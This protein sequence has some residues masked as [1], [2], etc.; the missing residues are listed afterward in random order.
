[1]D[2]IQGELRR[3]LPR[4]YFHPN[5]YRLL[6]IASILVLGVVS[7]GLLS[8]VAMPWYAKILL[9]LTI[10]YC[11]SVSGLLA[12]EILHGSVVRSR[13]WQDILGFICFLPYMI[14]PT[15]WRF[16]HN[17]L[18]H[19]HTQ[20]VIMDPDAFPTLKLFKQSRFSQRMFPFTPGSGHKRSYFYLFFWFSLNAQLIQFYFR[21]R[22]KAF[23]KVD[24]G[25]IN[26]ELILM[27]SI[28]LTAIYLVGVSAWLWAVV[29]PFFIMN[30]I[31]FSYI[32]TNH[33]MSP[34]TSKNNPL[35]NSV[36][37]LNHPLLEF[38]H[39][40][41]GYHVEHHLFPTVSGVYL[42]KI[43]QLLKDQCPEQYI[44]M[45]KWQA[46]KKLYKTPRIYKNANT[47]IHPYTGQTH[48]LVGALTSSDNDQSQPSEPSDQ[49]GQ[50]VQDV[51][52][53]QTGRA[54]QIGQNVSGS[55]PHSEVQ[56]G[57]TSRSPQ[58]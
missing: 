58:L 45:P 11:W 57:Q 33:N 19:S 10:G 36:T 16:W 14:S 51:E 31:P 49:V 25:R 38:L 21:F 53:G 32:S 15:F 43:H 56:D 5:Q 30:Y 28:H 9:S 47:L 46:L 8:F 4:H 55:I 13:G 48:T 41:F 52:N 24:H 44:Y 23:K 27:F 26:R 17:N 37:V 42:K 40:N 35:I 50:N 18:H 22:N 6:F 12:H 1:M 2:T 29:L 39:I 34:L 7:I 54:G 3:Q 20:R